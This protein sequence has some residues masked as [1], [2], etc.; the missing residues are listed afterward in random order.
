MHDEHRKRRLQLA[1]LTSLASRGLGFAA[2]FLT[3]PIIVAGLGVP[4]FAGYVSLTALVAWVS[5]L[6]FGLLPALTRELAAA[7]AVGDDD[8]AR[9]LIGAGFWFTLVIALLLAIITVAVAFSADVRSLV[10]IDRSVSASEVRLGFLAAMG[11]VALNFFA[12]TS[13][14]IRAG[15]QESYISNLL[16]LCA[17]VVIIV[18]LFGIVRTHGTIP[19]YVMALYGPLTLLLLFDLLRLAFLRPGLWPLPLPRIDALLRGSLTGLTRSSGTTW[20]GQMHYFLTVFGSVLLVSHLFSVA[21]TAAFGALMRAVALFSGV[22]GL[23]VWPL[24]PALTDA[25]GRRNIDWVRR[26]Y[27]R[28]ML[29]TAGSAVTIALVLAV[30]GPWLIHLWIGKSVSPSAE[31]CIFFAAYFVVSAVNFAGFNVLIALNS[32]KGVGLSYLVEAATVYVLAFLLRPTMGVEGIALALVLGGLSINFWYLPL[33]AYHRIRQLA[34][35]VDPSLAGAS[36]A[37]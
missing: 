36:V 21:D 19:I 31:L 33:K 14:A 17:N 11:L 10:G 24:V 32:S 22:V 2:Q 3:L 6:G 25:A 13:T 20:A 27:K 18:L 4:G 7:N 8:T 5:P 37:R 34:A 1:V 26:C 12:T 15:Y 16:S 28:L 30:G 29:A 35:A 9:R 23:F